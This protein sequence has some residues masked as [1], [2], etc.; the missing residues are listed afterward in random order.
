MN[1]IQANAIR[2]HFAAHV[3]EK[4]GTQSAAAQAYG[5]SAAMVS[6]VIHGG[7]KPSKVML[8]DMGLRKQLIYS[9]LPKK[10]D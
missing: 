4:Y 1:P 7:K 5:C 10:N 3:G 6:A 2:F 9:Y 8:D